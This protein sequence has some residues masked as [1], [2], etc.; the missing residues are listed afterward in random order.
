[1]AAGPANDLL[2]ALA[3][4]IVQLQRTQKRKGCDPEW[5]FF[6]EAVTGGAMMCRD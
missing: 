6:A 2:L 5:G 4:I 3:L 1:M